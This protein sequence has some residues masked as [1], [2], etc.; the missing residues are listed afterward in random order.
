MPLYGHG[1]EIR[2]HYHARRV[3]CS[4]EQLGTCGL[5]EGQAAV[6]AQLHLIFQPSLMLIA[7]ANA[8]PEGTA[9]HVLA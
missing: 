4:P 5:A 8:Q 1:D 3:G 6:I 9:P 2:S 7:D